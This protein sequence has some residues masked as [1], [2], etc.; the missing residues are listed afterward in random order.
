[1]MRIT[2]SAGGDRDMRTTGLGRGAF[3]VASAALAIFSLSYGDFAPGGSALPAWIP[4]PDIWVH[5][6]A[7]IVLAAAV[8]LCILRTAVASAVA[9]IAYF[10]LWAVISVPQIL[11]Q[12]LSF[13]GWYG[14]CEAGSSLAGAWILYR[15]LRS[16]IDS[17]VRGAQILFGATCIFYGASHFAF[18]DYTAGMVPRW[19]PWGLGLAYFTG[20][21]HI[22]GG[23][24]IIFRILPRL[25]AILEAIMMSLFGLL[26]W[27][28][29][30]FVA[31]KPAWATPPEN[32]WSELAVNTVLAAA[33]WVIALSLSQRLEPRV[34]PPLQ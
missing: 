19:L 1:M 5:A 9:V 34:Q 30:F 20:L 31:S 27:A 10:A 26:V 7:I 25:A 29:T 17:S 28:P 18:A 8:G 32:Q 33:A 23:V 16:R 3:A 11:A 4:W 6:V 21:A 14:F 12:P 15:M 24:G 13:G 22:A 2:E